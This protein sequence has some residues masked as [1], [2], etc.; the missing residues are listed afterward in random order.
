MPTVPDKIRLSRPQQIANYVTG[1]WR[2]Q[3]FQGGV[4]G[5]ES[6]R[7]GPYPENCAIYSLNCSVW[8]IFT[9]F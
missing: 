2:I 5:V 3:D 8:F 7:L 9:R 4:R 1:Q 6:A